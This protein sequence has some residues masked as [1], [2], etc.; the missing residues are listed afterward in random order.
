MGVAIFALVLVFILVGCSTEKVRE[1][2]KDRVDVAELNDND[3]D[4]AVV[5]NEK[6]DAV[7][8]NEKDDAVVDKE[9]EIPLH[10]AYQ[11]IMDGIELSIGGDGNQLIDLYGEPEGSDSFMGGYYIGYADMVFFVTYNES[12]EKPYGHVVRIAYMG[13]DQV[14]GIKVGMNADEVRNV[15]GEPD[16]I[17]QETEDTEL[18]GQSLRWE[19]KAGEY[20]VT[21]VFETKSKEVK[22]IY[23]ARK[24]EL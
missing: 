18:Y 22:G 10:N 4:D 5:D 8:D 6:D 24:S 2:E 21:L 20:V 16:E 11:G 3:K 14:Y 19:Y 12:K 7:V 13:K 1:L 9:R 23:L 17:H 15:L